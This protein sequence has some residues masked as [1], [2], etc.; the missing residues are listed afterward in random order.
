[1]LSSDGSSLLVVPAVVPGMLIEPK[2]EFTLML[3][4]ALSLPLPNAANPSLSEPSSPPADNVPPSQIDAAVGGVTDNSN[5]VVANEH[6]RQRQPCRVTF[7]RNLNFLSLI[8]V[9]FR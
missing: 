7:S 4:T 6:G 1:M 2:V 3:V 8:I 5:R 9:I